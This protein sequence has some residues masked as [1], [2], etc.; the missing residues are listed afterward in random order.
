M[1]S[2]DSI[3]VK[4]EVTRQ[5]ILPVLHQIKHALELFSDSAS[6][7]FIDIRSLPFGEQEELDLLEILGKGEVFA[8]LT[9]LGES[10][11][12]ETNYKGVWVTTHK[13]PDGLIAT[14][15]IEIT[16]F[17]EILKTPTADMEES[18]KKIA[19]YLDEKG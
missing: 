2:I 10:D 19:L 16:D 8:T 13:N 18:F 11:V 5:N 7:T 6:P 12:Y 14:R 15:S 1:A 9:A 17:P 4:S 3:A